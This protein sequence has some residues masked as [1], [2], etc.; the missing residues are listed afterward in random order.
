MNAPYVVYRVH[1]HRREIV[2]RLGIVNPVALETATFAAVSVA[3]SNQLG[4]ELH[5]EA[6]LVRK[7]TRRQAARLLPRL[8]AAEEERQ[9]AVIAG[10]L[11][12]GK[13]V[14]R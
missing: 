9:R 8:R 5:D 1:P 13:A 3:A 7:F 10:V 4:S 6:G 11:R 2:A 14:C 12:R